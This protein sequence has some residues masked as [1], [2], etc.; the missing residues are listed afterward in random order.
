MRNSHLVL[1]MSFLLIIIVIGTSSLFVI[2]RAQTSTTAVSSETATLFTPTAGAAL[3]KP[4]TSRVVSVSSPR[5]GT[6]VPFSASSLGKNR[7]LLGTIT[8]SFTIHR[9]TIEV[10]IDEAEVH[11]AGAIPSIYRFTEIR[12]AT[13]STPN[14]GD[15]VQ[16][17]SPSV[18]VT[19]I[20]NP[21][22]N[23]ILHNMTFSIPRTETELDKPYWLYFELFIRAD[24]DYS[25]AQSFSP[26]DDRDHPFYLPQR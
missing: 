25:K 5:E 15:Y 12:V 6:A 17:E 18:P 22:G 2:L 1:I 3:S 19:S 14:G 10:T 4:T 26:I 8:G 16:S 24:Q 13:I 20:P 21:D 11:F 7:L 23:Y 9:D